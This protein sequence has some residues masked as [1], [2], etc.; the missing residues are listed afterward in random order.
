M[1]RPTSD[2]D[3]ANAASIDDVEMLEEMLSRPTGEVVETMRRL[4]GDIL[5]LGVGGKIGPS[6][7][8]MARRASDAA[9]VPRRVIGV[10]RFSNAALEEQLRRDGIETIRCDLLDPEALDALPEAPNVVYLAAWKFGAT[11]QEAR[12]WAMNAYLPGMVCR[13]FAR[14]RIVAYSTGNVH[15]FVPADSGGSVE[16]DA[17]GP[18]GEYAMSCLGR[19]RIV[20]HFSRT[21]GTP[22]ALV[23]LNYAHEM[24]Y[25]VIVD[26]AAKVQLG[27]PID[28]RMG[29]FNAIWQGDSNAMTL[30][31]FDYV[32]SPPLVLNVTGPATLR[33][34]DVADQLGRRL[35]VEPRFSGEESP[36]ALLSNAGRAFALLGRPR[37]SEE[38]LVE[39]IADWRRRGGPMLGK[40]THFDARDGKF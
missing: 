21:F 39:W 40:P 13:R 31:L 1:P 15:P 8:R 33:V 38:R 19:E 10:A 26:L 35:G 12:L 27:E 28:L 20:E 22:A 25:G 5:L 29:Y 6:L 24:R 11:G 37:V 36:D 30:R 34:R 23:R 9:G 4:E 2:D 16:T 7:A 3:P 32:A 17:P 18:V 14:S